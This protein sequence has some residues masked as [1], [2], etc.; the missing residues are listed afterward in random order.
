MLILFL[1]NY[2]NLLIFRPK[3][4]FQLLYFFHLSLLFA[5]FAL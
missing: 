5:N 2:S 4:H 1:F 3:F